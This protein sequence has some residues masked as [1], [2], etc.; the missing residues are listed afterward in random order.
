MVSILPRFIFPIPV[1]LVFSLFLSVS[2]VTLTIFN[3]VGIFMGIRRHN[4]Q[5]IDAISGINVSVILRREK[6]AAIDML[7]VIG[8]LL[9][10]IA[11][12]IVVSIFKSVTLCPEPFKVLHLWSSTLI[13]INSSINPVIY[14]VRSSKI[15]NAVRSLFRC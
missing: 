8:V 2:L 12:A 13:Y 1:R 6:K 5:V 4:N 7:I 10:F 15:R 3:H 9:L 14:L 11:P